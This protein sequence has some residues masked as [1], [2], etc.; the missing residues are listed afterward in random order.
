M[1][2][3]SLTLNF[4]PLQNQIFRLLCKKSG[5]KLNQRE[6]AKNLKATPT[7]IAK[8]LPLMARANLIL[9]EKVGTMNLNWV[10]LNRSEHTLRLKQ[11]ENL[12]QL[13]ELDLINF[14]ED[15]HP[16]STIILFG[17]YMRGEDTVKSDID[18]AVIGG[19][20]EQLNLKIFE[21]IL[22]RQI[23][24]SAF[25]SLKDLSVEFKENLF[26]G[27]VLSGGIEL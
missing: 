8:A 27:I 4:T 5:L 11:I 15:A 26:N 7:G 24:I 22:E 25:N 9:I 6:I 1:D 12:R 17:S 23:N 10:S 16:G 14:L 19:K 3:N 20:K 13:Y 21:K 18:I 2:T